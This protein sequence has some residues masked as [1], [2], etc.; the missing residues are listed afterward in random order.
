MCRYYGETSPRRR[1]AGA[2]TGCR[3]R[4]SISSLVCAG[5]CSRPLSP[6]RPTRTLVGS[7]LPLQPPWFSLF[8]F[9]LSLD[10]TLS[11]SLP[12]V[13]LSPKVKLDEGWYMEPTL[14]NSLLQTVCSSLCT[15]QA[16]IYI[17]ICTP[18]SVN[19]DRIYTDVPLHKTLT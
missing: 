12:P 14:Q 15:Q 4:K 7:S 3:T 11:A 5:S 2:S 8:G 9:V 13:Q 17:G 1:L 16:S 19:C 6:S 18:L 10:R